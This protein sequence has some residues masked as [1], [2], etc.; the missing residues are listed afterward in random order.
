MY[1]LTAELHPS[2]I[3]SGWWRGWNF[4]TNNDDYAVP[5]AN[6]DFRVPA[7]P[8]GQGSAANTKIV[9]LFLR[10]MTQAET[11]DWRCDP[12]LIT[13]DGGKVAA[14]RIRECLKSVCSPA[15]VEDEDHIREPASRVRIRVSIYDRFRDS[16]L[17]SLEDEPIEDGFSHPAEEIISNALDAS[18]LTCL[19]HL[20]R[21][22]RE[23]VNK[24]SVCSGLL[25]CVGRIEPG[26]AGS[27]GR[28]FASRGLTHTDPEVRESAVRALEFWGGSESISMLRAHEEPISWLADYITEVIED[29]SN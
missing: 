17:R 3:E 26:V 12:E 23:C 21:L 10:A 16:F 1:D 7:T 13:P 20:E 27:W 9:G 8:G 6:E 11:L 2:A 28:D 4:H 25:R 22:Y 5:P 18:Q 24:P 19:E 14:L 15:L 29:L